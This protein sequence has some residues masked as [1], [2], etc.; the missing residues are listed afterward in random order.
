MKSFT[1]SC[2]ISGAGKLDIYMK[3]MK[4]EYLLK[5]YTNINSKCIKDLDVR[6]DLIKLLE[7]NLGRTLSHK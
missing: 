5:S 4:L 6:P 1:E 3:R 2:Q 7:E